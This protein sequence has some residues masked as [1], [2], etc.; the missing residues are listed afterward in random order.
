M[1]SGSDFYNYKKF[2]SVVLMALVDANYCFTFID[3]G[4]QGRL[5][6]GAVFRNTQLY[7]KIDKKQLN[8]PPDEPLDGADK[9]FPY[10]FVGDDAFGLSSTILKPFPATYPKGSIQRIFNYRLSRARRVVENVFGIMSSV[11]RVLRKPML[12]EPNKV[13]TIVMACC[14]L[15]NYL[16]KSYTSRSNYMPP[17]SFDLETEGQILPGSWRADQDNITSLIPLQKVPR[18]QSL[19]AKN[20]REEFAEYFSG[21]GKVSWQ[22]K[23]S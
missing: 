14:F 20:I 19:D 5:S 10:L 3:C 12:L 15:H 8:L 2:F 4:C 16:R 23:Y 22:D 21:V 13:T 17:G 9:K 11:F 7:E 6:D 18:K 1:N